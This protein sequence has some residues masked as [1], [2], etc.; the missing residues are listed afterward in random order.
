MSDKYTP[1]D[2]MVDGGVGI[3]LGVLGG[4]MFFPNAVGDTV[5]NSISCIGTKFVESF[6]GSG[7]TVEVEIVLSTTTLP[8]AI[9]L[10]QGHVLAVEYY[11]EVNSRWD[12]PTAFSMVDQGTEAQL[13]IG[14]TATLLENAN[15]LTTD[16][17]NWMIDTGLVGYYKD[18]DILNYEP[19][20]D[21]GGLL[22]VEDPLIYVATK[23]SVELTVTGY[24]IVYSC[25]I[26]TNLQISG[27]DFPLLTWLGPYNVRI[28]SNAD[29]PLQRIYQFSF[30]INV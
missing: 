24:K 5:I 14:L 15:V 20:L 12:V 30:D 23:T 4:Q 21:D 11:L 22:P 7:Q 17:E 28:D 26:Y 8:N 10:P 27:I 16:Y 29:I 18:P 19:T 3:R 25:R 9:T 1:Q 2:S 13:D 6:E